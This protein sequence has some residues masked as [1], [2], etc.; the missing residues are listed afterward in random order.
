MAI[1]MIEREYAELVDHSAEGA[2]ALKEINDS[3]EVRWIYSFLSADKHRTFC[4]YEAESAEAIRR[5]AERAGIPAGAIVE[6]SG[7]VTPDGQL[8]PV[9]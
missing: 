6:V 4:L 3:E 9:G 7:R 5:A 2:A 1:F 8:H